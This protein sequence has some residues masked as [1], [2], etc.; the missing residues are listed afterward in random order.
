MTIHVENSQP[1]QRK[2]LSSQLARHLGRRLRFLR[3]QL[4]ISQEELAIRAG[5]MD[6]A[7]ISRLESARSVPNVATLARISAALGVG[8]SDLV[9][10]MPTESTSI[11]PDANVGARPHTQR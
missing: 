7:H 2:E 5:G 8:L 3:A 6:R 11:T 10:G 1:T 9:R 4:S